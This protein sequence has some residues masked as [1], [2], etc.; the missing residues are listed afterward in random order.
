LPPDV[1]EQ[2]IDEIET[3]PAETTPIQ[4]L[5]LEDTLADLNPK[6][7]IT[8]DAD[9]SLEKAVR[10]MN[11][12]NIGCLLITDDNDKLIGIFTERDVLMRVTGLV[13]DLAAADVGDYMTADPV[14]L[15]ADLPIA[16]ALHEMSVHGFRH[17][18]L[19]D[20]ENHPE[21]IISFRDV[22]DHMQARFAD[23]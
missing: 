6:P 20:G 11:T 8:V 17:L 19:V 10:Q 13:D 5:M 4:D 2:Y 3:E 14:A 23:N 9:T 18:P 12:H 7:P 15:T 22:I 21:G 16:Q 1:D